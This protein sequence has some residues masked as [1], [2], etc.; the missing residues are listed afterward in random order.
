MQ[1]I[2]HT[3]SSYCPLLIKLMQ[4][5]SMNVAVVAYHRVDVPRYDMSV[6]ANRVMSHASRWIPRQPTRALS[7]IFTYTIH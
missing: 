7:S 6:S 3:S 1:S 2:V 4:Y 5:T